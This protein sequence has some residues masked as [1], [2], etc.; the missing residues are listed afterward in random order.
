MTSKQ[1]SHGQLKSTMYYKVVFLDFIS[2][3]KKQIFSSKISNKISETCMILSTFRFTFSRKK[4]K[5]WMKTTTRNQ[6]LIL[7]Y[8]ARCFLRF[9]PNHLT[10]VNNYLHLVN[11]KRSSSLAVFTVNL[12]TTKKFKVI[13]SRLTVLSFYLKLMKM[14][15][16]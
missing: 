10:E 5:L 9:L 1:I 16:C 7:L 12:F 4:I 13:Y 6:I 8:N 11:L 2:I 15:F 3:S 14:C